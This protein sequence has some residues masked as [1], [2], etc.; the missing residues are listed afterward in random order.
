[1]SNAQTPLLDEGLYLFLT[2]PNGPLAGLLT[3]ANVFEDYVPPNSPMPCLMYQQVSEVTDTTLDGPSGYVETRYQFNFYGQDKTTGTPG[4]GRVAANSLRNA[5]RLQFNGL[6]GTLPNGI[7]LWNVIKM[8]SIAPHF[9]TQ[10]QTYQLI[11]DYKI[12][13]CEFQAGDTLPS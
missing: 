10:A 6:T 12:I 11:T 4:S 2:N 1:M 8:N 13:Y 9:D 3:D 5:V 7:Q